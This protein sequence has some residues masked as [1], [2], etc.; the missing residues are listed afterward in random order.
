MNVVSLGPQRKM[1]QVQKVLPPHDQVTRGITLNSQHT[2]THTQM[3]LTYNKRQHK[4]EALNFDII[5]VF[6][7]RK[8]PQQQLQ[9]GKKV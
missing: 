7:L 6:C 8:F 1:K 2:H 3:A 5:S 4:A 9:G